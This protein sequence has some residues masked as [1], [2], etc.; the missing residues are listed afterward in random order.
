LP[1]EYLTGEATAINL[2][3]RNTDAQEFIAVT[4]ADIR[5]GG[6]A[7]YAAGRDFISMPYFEAFKDADCFYATIFHE[8]GHNADIRIMPRRT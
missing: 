5:D 8:L 2:D 7:Y 6:E 4:G 1:D 3:E